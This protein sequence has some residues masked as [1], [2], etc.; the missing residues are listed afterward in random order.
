MAPTAYTLALDGANSFIELH[1][2]LDNLNKSDTDALA[3]VGSRAREIVYS[4]QIPKTVE[5]Q[6]RNAWKELKAIAGGD[7]LT[8]AVRSSATAEDLPTASF[9][10]Q[11]DT[12]LNI[13]GEEMLIEGMNYFIG[14]QSSGEMK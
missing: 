10:G 3:K 4:A 8:V 7:D 1:Q 14:P 5:L 12:F 13:K 6:L 9:A 11:H 2:L